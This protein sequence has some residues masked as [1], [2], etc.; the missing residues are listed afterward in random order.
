MTLMLG[1][2]A[3]AGIL[4]RGIFTEE[5]RTNHS[6]QAQSVLGLVDS[7]ESVLVFEGGIDPGSD[8]KMDAWT[9]KCVP[10]PFPIKHH[11]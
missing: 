9:T 3:S 1:C 4:G 5:V 8:L 2:N 11:D 10:F 7:P 6:M